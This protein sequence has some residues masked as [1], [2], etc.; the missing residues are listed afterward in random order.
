[1][2][3]RTKGRGEVA[4]LN[5]QIDTFYR[6]NSFISSIDDLEQLLELIM[7]EA[8]GAV[9]GE[10]SCIALY[11]ASDERIH[12][13]ITSGEK[14]DQVRHISLALGQGILG[15]VAATNK[16][17][18]VDNAPQD[19]RFEPSVD[20]TT[21]F[22][23]RA[24][25]AAPI[26][27]R[28]QLLGV[29]EVINKR[30]GPQFTDQDTALLEVV[31]NQ[32][33][34]AIDNCRLLERV[35]QSER[36]SVIGRLST[37]IL[38][39]FKTPIF[40]IRGAARQL[41]NQE[42]EEDRRRDLSNLILDEVNRFSGMTQEVADYSGGSIR[43]QLE[44][45]ELGPWLERVAFFLRE[46]LATSGVD[47]ITDLEYRGPVYFDWERMRRVVINIASN[48]KDA[49]PD[50]G[51]LTIATSLQGENLQLSFKDTGIGIAPELSSKIFEPFYTSGKD[52]GT[53]LGLAIARDIVERH[54]GTIEF[55]SRVA[56]NE[57]GGDPGTTFII[58]MPVS[59]NQPAGRKPAALV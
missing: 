6:V 12:I 7:Q 53:G 29:L 59:L 35:V 23:T 57:D 8:E 32:A 34:I 45:I 46:S 10:A 43:L 24:I 1:M 33:A 9:E 16:A 50:G 21:G 44:E 36:L 42:L 26:V 47:L 51:A 40:T 5:R 13:E 39:D 22:K 28:G 37:S 4:F 3:S 54:G 38:H 31:A 58:R 17:L 2:V 41:A 52:H 48:A 49:M 18:R 27:R 30:G 15:V 56:G 20:I 55:E 25:V 14:R 19:P 11:D